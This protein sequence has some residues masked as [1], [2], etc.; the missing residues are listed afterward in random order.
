MTDRIGF[1]NDSSMMVEGESELTGMNN[2][3]DLQEQ[4]ARELRAVYELGLLHGIN[5]Q[6]MA[7]VKNSTLEFEDYGWSLVE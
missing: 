5:T 3:L 4:Y 6:S 1:G 7:Q 2:P